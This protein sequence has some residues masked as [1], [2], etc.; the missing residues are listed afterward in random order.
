VEVAVAVVTRPLDREE[1]NLRPIGEGAGEDRADD[2]AAGVPELVAVVAPLDEVTGELSEVVV[3][4]GA[5]VNVDPLEE[6]GEAHRLLVGAEFKECA[7]DVDSSIIAEGGE[8]LRGEHS[9]LRPEGGRQVVV[10]VDVRPASVSA[11]GSVSVA[12]SVS[13]PASAPAVRSN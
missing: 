2:L 9:G 1:P 12:V 4:V 11:A 10:G 5:V 8:H 13:A 6:I 7:Q 3:E